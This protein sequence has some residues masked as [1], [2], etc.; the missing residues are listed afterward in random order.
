M[1]DFFLIKFSYYVFEM[2]HLVFFQRKRHDFVELITHHLLSVALITIVYNL[3]MLTVAPVMLITDCTDIFV[4]IFKL[5]V[6]VT[7]E[8]YQVATYAMMLTSWFYLRIYVLPRE[9]VYQF[10]A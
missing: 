10:W 7:P 8:R 5:T 2:L 6:D 3:N 9:L 4:A 1:D